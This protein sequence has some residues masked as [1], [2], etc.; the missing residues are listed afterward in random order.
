MNKNIKSIPR[1]KRCLYRLC[2]EPMNMNYQTGSSLSSV[3]WLQVRIFGS[4]RQDLF[5]SLV[6]PL[7]LR[8]PNQNIIYLNLLKKKY[9]TFIC[10][11]KLL[12]TFLVGI[13]PWTLAR[14]STCLTKRASHRQNTKS[15]ILLK[16]K[17]DLIFNI[18]L[19]TVDNVYNS[20]AYLS[21]QNL[22][23]TALVLPAYKILSMIYQCK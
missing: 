22:T 18:R 12:F 1:R 21:A 15:F 11:F 13:S 7:R 9:C 17:V 23:L 20:L 16:I 8:N 14:W 4:L 19:R 3:M 5:R 10:L 6:H 2:T